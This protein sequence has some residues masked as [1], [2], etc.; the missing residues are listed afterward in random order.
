MLSALSVPLAAGL[1]AFTVA[2]WW[3][4]PGRIGYAVVAL[5]VTAFAITYDLVGP[6]FT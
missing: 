2:A 4:L 6:P 3:R 1:L 5:A